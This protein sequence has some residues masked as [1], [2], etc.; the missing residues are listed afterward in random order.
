VLSAARDQEPA[1]RQVAANLLRDAPPTAAGEAWAVLAADPSRLVRR[2]TIDAMV[3]VNREQ[4]RTLL[5]QGLADQD[6]WVRWKALHG[7]ASLGPAA[8]RSAIE[9]LR[10]DP[11]FRVRLEAA[12]ALQQ[13]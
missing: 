3:D 9:E 12:A 13:P 8:S 10:S 2:A 5:E 4:L 6:P 1:R 11:D 7:L